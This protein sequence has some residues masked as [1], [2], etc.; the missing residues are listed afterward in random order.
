ML[1]VI[2]IGVG[3]SVF[4]LS[5]LQKGIATKFVG[6]IMAGLI[7][8]LGVAQL[9]QIVAKPLYASLTGKMH[10]QLK[11]AKVKKKSEDNSVYKKSKIGSIF[12][13]VDKAWK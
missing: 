11:S 9:A 12:G 7:I 8:M 1:A 10:S 6:W 5:N 4:L 13:E 2:V 3:F